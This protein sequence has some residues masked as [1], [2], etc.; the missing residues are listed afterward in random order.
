MVNIEQIKAEI[1]ELLEKGQ[2]LGRDIGD[3]NANREPAEFFAG[4][5]SWYSAALAVMRSIAPDR[6]E[7]F[8]DIYRPDRRPG[9]ELTMTTYGISDYLQGIPF[10]HSRIIASNKFYSQRM[11]LLS[12]VGRLDSAIAD[13]RGTVRASLFDSEIDQAQDLLNKEHIRAAGVIA[14]VVLESHLAAICSNRNM[15]LGRKRQTIGNLKEALRTSGI[16]DLPVARQIEALA[17]VRNLCGHKRGREPT[18]EEVQT[19]VDKTGL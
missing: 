13:I 10:S 5:Q 1:G 14:G 9:S 17:D 15:S 11:I 3:D 16:I 12:T 18:P 7:E 8:T 2:A 6:L 4:Y 19:L